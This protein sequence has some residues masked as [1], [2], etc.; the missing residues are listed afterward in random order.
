M[1]TTISPT[2]T[3][4]SKI[5]EP[6]AVSKPKPSSLRDDVD[7]D[8]EQL[9]AEGYA[10]LRSMIDA[11]ALRQGRIEA[12]A[13]MLFASSGIG[14]TVLAATLAG[15]GMPFQIA[16]GITL[17]LTFLTCGAALRSVAVRSTKAIGLEHFSIM[18]GCKGPSPVT[19]FRRATIE[20]LGPIF[21]AAEEANEQRARRLRI[22]QRFA[23]LSFLGAVASAAMALLSQAGK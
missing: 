12:R 23:V 8:N 18:K 6:L 21:T 3:L 15:K 22:A 7:V 16:A 5:S 19:M 9:V 11:E 20:V 17:V 4:A 1:A 10:L 13:A 2:S 14:A